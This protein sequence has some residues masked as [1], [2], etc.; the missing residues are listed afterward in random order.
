MFMGFCSKCG[1]NL[2]DDVYF[3]PK[4]GTRTKTGK[5]AGVSAPAEELKEAFS[6]AGQEI[7]KAF[8]LAA[9]EIHE[10]FKTARENIRESTTTKAIVCS[11]CGEK[12]KGDSNFCY[13]CG[14]KLS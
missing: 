5:E 11:H 14:R 13:K 9:K 12:N 3:C 1:E 8:R 10:A 2:P 4:C 6:I 7:E